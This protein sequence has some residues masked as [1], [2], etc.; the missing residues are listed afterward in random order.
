[1]AFDAVLHAAQANAGWAFK[2]LHDA[3]AP[4]IAGY[5]RS[6]GGSDA[7]G[8][9]NEILFAAFRALHRF[10]GDEAQFRSWLFTIAHNRVIDDRRRQAREVPRSTMVSAHDVMVAGG[11]V[12]DEAL[13]RIADG[14]TRAL[15]DRLTPDQRNVLLLRVVGDLTIRQA[16]QVLGKPPGAVKA[17]QRRALAALQRQFSLKGVSL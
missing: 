8:M 6:Q 4:A 14:E 9:T 11:D 12:E 17:L 7:E 1:V 15:L 3:F 5:V 10:R 16:A 13:A 2:L